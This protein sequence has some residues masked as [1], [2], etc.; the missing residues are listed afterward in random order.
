MNPSDAFV[1]SIYQ[2]DD[3]ESPREW[4][5]MGT[6]ACWHRRYRLGDIQPSCDPGE[7]L[8]GLDE[9]CLVLPV[10]LYDHSG[11]VISTAPFSC[12]FDSGQVGHIHT[13]PEIISDTY[14]SNSPEAR[15][16]ARERLIEEISIYNDYLQGNCWGYSV[17]RPGE[18]EP[19][20]CG[21][22]IGDSALEDMKSQEDSEIAAAL[23]A[24][25]ESRFE[26]RR[27]A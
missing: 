6:I 17:L 10:Y 23:D 8:R 4:S 11:I 3:A 19:S 12:R 2:D 14:G 25:W 1:V 7:Y 21:G 27:S 15:A 13:T 5:N 22:F 16:S 18:T 20:F 9:D 24:A 26:Q